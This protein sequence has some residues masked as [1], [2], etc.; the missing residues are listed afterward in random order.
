V[1]TNIY[2]LKICKKK[3]A[4]KMLNFNKKNH[5]NNNKVYEFIIYSNK[6]ENKNYIPKKWQSKKWT[7]EDI[8]DYLK[9]VVRHKDIT[10]ADLKNT[11]KDKLNKFKNVGGF[12]SGE[13]KNNRRTL[14]NLVLKQV[15]TFDIENTE[16]ENIEKFNIENI[17]KILRK[18]NLSFIT[19]ETFSSTIEDRRYRLILFL[20]NVVSNNDEYKKACA[21]LMHSINL[22]VK[23]V[24]TTCTNV[25]HFMFKRACP[26]DAEHFFEYNK[27]LEFDANKYLS[28][29][30]EAVQLIFLE[31]KNFKKI[32]E[33]IQKTLD[34][35]SK[36]LIHPYDYKGEVGLFN[37]F[38]GS[39]S[40]V[41]QYL[42]NKDGTDAY[43][44]GSNLD[45]FDYIAGKGSSGVVLYSFPGYDSTPVFMYS[46]HHTDVLSEKRLSS[47]HAL[48]SFYF[49]DVE[50]DNEAFK[51]ALNYVKNKIPGFQKFL[52]DQRL[53]EDF[54]DFEDEDNSVTTNLHQQNKTLLNFK[55]FNINISIDLYNLNL[56]SLF[57]QHFEDFF[58]EDFN[59][60]IEIEED[61]NIVITCLNKDN[62]INYDKIKNSFS[63]EIIDKELLDK[64]RS[65]VNKTLKEEIKN[66]YIYNEL[67]TLIDK[68]SLNQDFIKWNTQSA[69]A[70]GLGKSFSALKV[71]LQNSLNVLN[72][73]KK[74]NKI[75]FIFTDQ[76]ANVSELY[77]KMQELLYL[78]LQNKTISRNLKIWLQ[79]SDFAALNIYKMT[80]QTKESKD[81]TNGI[82]APHAYLL[83]QGHTASF[84]KRMLDYME[85]PVEKEFIIDECKVLQDVFTRIQLN[86]FYTSELD[87]DNKSEKVYKKTFNFLEFNSLAVDQDTALEFDYNNSISDLLAV[88]CR[89]VS[90][91]KEKGVHKYAVNINGAKNILD[92]LIDYTTVQKEITSTKM[93]D[94]EFDDYQVG[95]VN[96][97]Q[98]LEVKNKNNADEKNYIKIFNNAK[99]LALFTI[100]MIFIKDNIKTI[101]NDFEE[102]KQFTK[103]WDIN[104]YRSLKYALQNKYSSTLQNTFVFHML[105]RLPYLH[106][107]YKDDPFCKFSFISAHKCEKFWDDIKVD[108]FKMYENRVNTEQINIIHLVRSYRLN[109]LLSL[110]IP[111]MLKNYATNTLIFVDYKKTAIKL[112]NTVEM[113][114]CVVK[115][116]SEGET[117]LHLGH[118]LTQKTNLTQE[119]RNTT[120]TYTEGNEARSKSYS[121]QRVIIDGETL[122]NILRRIRYSYKDNSFYFV[123]EDE[124]RISQAIQTTGRTT[125]RDCLKD[126]DVKRKVIIVAA[127]E[128]SSVPSSLL[129]HYVKYFGKDKILFQ[130]VTIPTNKKDR[131]TKELKNIL[132]YTEEYLNYKEIEKYI[133]PD[134]RKTVSKENAKKFDDEEIYSF[135][136]NKQTNHYKKNNKNL[137]DSALIPVITKEFGISE[138]Q[139]KN[140]KKK[141]AK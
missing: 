40:N 38:I 15:V 92:Q 126:V 115:A 90:D 37:E 86:C 72:S 14:D 112:L 121:D 137:K 28:A 98:H 127:S 69:I 50:D 105:Y 30:E 119:R 125:T 48:K 85:N 131:A 124:Y 83:P 94:L 78:S 63:Y 7:F 96:S 12:C 65:F 87:F 71:M 114:H 20:K 53:E 39:I 25:E 129:E 44:P 108:N 88:E 27:G 130:K 135:Y 136:I 9:P 117:G 138:R 36:N 26:S 46:F 66:F 17:I 42:K 23:Y 100:K 61:E 57:C 89:T 139:F 76:L 99:C 45:R 84:S 70:T 59:I 123:D 107:L 68:E 93:C 101:I 49:W 18:L 21:S 128:N 116:I 104:T 32:K 73:N 113:P 3:G 11:N 109:S 60:Q 24:D 95:F 110:T 5:I 134:N 43:A 55:D 10:L 102:F 81:K 8:I 67:N 52:D 97:I 6:N 2:K 51:L 132:N 122:P 111:K 106:E 19:H 91:Y 58:D 120:I 41:F 29:N 13:F 56:K 79:S 62:H 133:K 54:A 118:I 75:V 103:N 77:Y 22:N 141:F 16:K 1:C 64:V 74:M 4:K 31:L 82:I 35:D 47:F 34:K 33:N 80:S 140:I